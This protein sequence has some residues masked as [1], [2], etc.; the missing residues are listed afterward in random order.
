[1]TRDKRLRL[2]EQ[3][4]AR[5]LLAVNPVGVEFRVNTTF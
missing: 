5:Q 1:M 2:M 3:L 4:E